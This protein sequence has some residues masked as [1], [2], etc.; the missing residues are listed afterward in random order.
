MADPQ[1]GWYAD[2]AGDATKLRWWDGTQWTENYT[3]AQGQ[4]PAVATAPAPAPAQSQ[5]QIA[6]STPGAGA[7]QQEQQSYAQPA[8]QQPAYTQ[9][10]YTQPAQKSNDEGLRL[11][12]FIFCIVS[13]VGCCWM[14]IPLAWMIPMTVYCWGIYKG[15]KANTT[16]FGVCTLI[17]FSLIGGILLLCSTKDA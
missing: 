8:Y 2:P 5:S 15:T 17:F 3:S 9:P 1:A 13:L 4:A 12:A 10:A 16:V 14:I 6:P 11:A 7:Y